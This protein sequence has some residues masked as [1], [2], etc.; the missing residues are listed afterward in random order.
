MRLRIRVQ[1]GNSGFAAAI[2]LALLLIGFLVGVD[3]LL[4]RLVPDH[5]PFLEGLAQGK[6]RTQWLLAAAVASVPWPI[7]MGVIR[8]LRQPRQPRPGPA[9]QD[10]PPEPPAVANMLTEDFDPS[11]EALPATV[12]DLAARRVIDIEEAGQEEYRVRLRGRANASLL[13]FEQRVLRLLRS[14]AVD[15][16]V[17]MRALTT[18][19]SDRARRWWKGFRGEVIDAAQGRRLS[20]DLWGLPTLVALVLIALPAVPLWWIA[21]GEIA[22]LGYLVVVAA[23]VGAAKDGRRQRDTPDGY[24][25][26]AR[27]LGVRR[28]YRQGAFDHL[29]PTAVAVWERHLAYATAL[30]V[31]HT[32]I[33]AIPMGADDDHRAW[34]AY[35]GEWRLLRIRYPRLWPPGWGRPPSYALFVGALQTFVATFAIYG[36]TRLWSEVEG[37]LPQD[38]VGPAR[39]AYVVLATAFGSFGFRAFVQAALSTADLGTSQQRTGLILRVRSYGSD[40]SPRH[41]VALDDATSEELR[42]FRIQPKLWAMTDFT[43]YREATLTVTPCLGYV[44][45]AGPARP[46]P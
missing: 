2:V 40:D 20:R 1:L 14:R 6:V 4:T 31:A 5:K 19:P 17:P 45:A 3:A 16:V 25:A 42:A 15:G 10:P 34:S 46:A 13:P 29:P 21:S 12:I 9:T 26:A 28:T 33:R 39:L 7:A 44:R 23:F 38:A 30:G 35:G 43:E 36:F 8:F 32:T 24:R 22:A 27:A 18:G 37:A 41:Y 11:R